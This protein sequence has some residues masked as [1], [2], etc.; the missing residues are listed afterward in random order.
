MNWLNENA[1]VLVL[2]LSVIV[3]AMLALSIYLLFYLKNRI[4]VQR[5]SFL[6]FYSASMETQN[7]YADFTIGNKTLNTIGI[8][9]IGL[10]NGKVSYDLTELY[11]EKTGLPA[12]AKIVIGQRSSLKFRLTK[13]EL[14]RVAVP[15]KDG[16]RTVSVLRMYAVDLSGNL[17][18][19]K[20][21]PVRKLL[22]ELLAEGQALSAPETKETRD[23]E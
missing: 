13:E 18:H 14:L 22:R 2:V 6:G 16:K 20:V 23:P 4:A 12:E 21:R 10:R 9:E 8:S 11:R 7:R 19:G 15:A 17:Y 5:L 3:I 1:G